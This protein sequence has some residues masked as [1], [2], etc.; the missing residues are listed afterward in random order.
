MIS[1]YRVFLQVFL[2]G[3]SSTTNKMKRKHQD[4]ATNPPKKK[5]HTASQPGNTARQEPP[6]PSINDLKKQ[7]RN[8]KR[9]LARDDLPADTRIVQERALAEYEKELGEETRRR[10]RR[11]MIGRYHF[12]RFLGGYTLP[13]GPGFGI[14]LHSMRLT[15]PDRKSASKE[16][17]K[18]LRKEKEVAAAEKTGSEAEEPDKDDDGD[19][20]DGDLARKIHIAR[21]NLN[22]TIYYPLT[23]KY[24]SLYADKQQEKKE[25]ESRKKEGSSNGDTE[26]QD[27]SDNNAADVGPD[28]QQP[29]R[30]AMWYVVEKCM[31]GGQEKLDRLREGKSGDVSSVDVQPAETG[32]G[33]SRS[34]RSKRKDKKDGKGEKDVEMRD[35]HNE[36]EDVNHDD[37]SDGGF[38]EE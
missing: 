37:D 22:Y 38:F 24:I 27:L 21:V 20:G 10:E 9:L 35:V 36:A 16:L 6:H 23:E 3:V 14:A 28:S 15:I 32:S 18:L 17:K 29:S 30:P 31:E 33:G 5:P 34:D 2:L 8:A 13:L 19:A 26:S 4:P 7:I 25:R 12:V 11:D 1:R